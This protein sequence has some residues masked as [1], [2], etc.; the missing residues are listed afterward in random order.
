LSSYNFVA[1]SP[2]LFIDPD[3]RKIVIGH[4]TADEQEKYNSIITMARAENVY[5]E[6][7]YSALEN[8]DGEFFISSGSAVVGAEGQFQPRTDIDGNY[9]QKGGTIT[10]PGLNVGDETLLEE[11]FHG[12]QQNLYVDNGPL[13]SMLQL[14]GA[15][16][17]ETKLLENVNKINVTGRFPSSLEATEGIRFIGYDLADDPNASPEMIAEFNKALDVF[18]AVHSE[19]KDLFEKDH[20]YRP[21]D[22]YDL[23]PTTEVT[24]N[25][26]LEVLQQGAKIQTERG[27][28][29]VEGNEI[30]I[31][32][33]D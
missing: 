20:G 33:D 30:I 25:A 18:I 10:L 17:L 27:G 3:G 23:K 7:I 15:I 12:F 19:N 28:S 2:L 13:W 24:L 11:F 6:V 29:K 22:S 31:T 9:L 32:P 1:N 8:S 26:L 16:E 21:R 4:L 5:F 14:G